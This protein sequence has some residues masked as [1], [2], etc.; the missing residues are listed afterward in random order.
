MI[1]N[2]KN[3]FKII[4]N[5]KHR[6]YEVKQKLKK[7]KK[8]KDSEYNSINISNTQINTNDVVT[9]HLQKHTLPDLQI[10]M[11]PTFLDK[12][13]LREEFLE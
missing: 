7:G 8:K 12:V 2:L 13:G 11:I 5:L 3:L 4:T 6:R 1:L 10:N 9:K